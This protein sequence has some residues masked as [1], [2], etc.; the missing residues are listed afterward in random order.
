MPI[1]IDVQSIEVC[2]SF[3]RLSGA[4]GGLPEVAEAF[5]RILKT[6]RD[7]AKVAKTIKDREGKLEEQEWQNTQVFLR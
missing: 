6:Q 3:R 5:N 4:S 2:G 1:R 7:Y